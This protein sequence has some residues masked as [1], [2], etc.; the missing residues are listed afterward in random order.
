MRTLRLD[1][2]FIRVSQDPQEV[3]GDFLGFALSLGNLS[4]RPPAEEFAEIFSPAGRGMRLPDTFAAYRA[5]EPDGVPEEFGEMAA[6]EL[7]RRE[8]WVLTRLR[9]GTAPVSALVEGP[10][11]RHLLGEA[12]ALRDAVPPG[13]HGGSR[14]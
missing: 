5:G 6:E 4:G 8:I 10:E 12:L 7:E 3:I 11:L 2:P 13:D 9:Y 1:G 14:S